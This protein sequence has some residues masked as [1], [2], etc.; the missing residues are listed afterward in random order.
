MYAD[1]PVFQSVP[2]SVPSYWRSG[3]SSEGQTSRRLKVIDYQDGDE[4]ESAQGDG[5]FIREQNVQRGASLWL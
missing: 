5:Q 4:G 3:R 1:I 2:A